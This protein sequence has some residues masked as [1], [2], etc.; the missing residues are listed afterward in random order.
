[1]KNKNNVKKLLKLRIYDFLVGYTVRKN[2]QVS[3][4]VRTESL[5]LKRPRF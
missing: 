2:Y 5:M 4:Q 3:S 1:M